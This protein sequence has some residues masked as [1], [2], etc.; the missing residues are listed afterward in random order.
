MNKELKITLL[1][2]LVI[3]IFLIISK[4]VEIEAFSFCIGAIYIMVFDVINKWCGDSNE[5]KMD[6]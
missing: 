3:I 1:E 2:L 5:Q 4:F 6:K